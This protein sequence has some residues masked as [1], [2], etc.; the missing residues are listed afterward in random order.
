[1]NGVETPVPDR[2][3]KVR[4]ATEARAALSAGVIST[5]EI[6][7]RFPKA[8]RRRASITAFACFAIFYCGFALYVR[9]VLPGWVFAPAGFFLFIRYFDASHEDIHCRDRD[10]RIWNV[11]RLVSFVLGPLHLCYT[12]LARNHR[13]HHAHEGKEG[14]PDRWMME[15]GWTAAAL[16]SLTQP[17]QALVRHIKANGIDRR[18]ALDLGLH[19]SIWIG[20]AYVCT[21]PQFLLYNAL[22]RFGNGASWFV[23]THVLH[24]KVLYRGFAPVRP[25]AWLRAAWILLIGRNNL[26]AITYHFL[27]HAYGF[28]PARRLPD[29]SAL[30]M[31]RTIHRVA[32]P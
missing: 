31:R 17:E 28:V 26:N 3:P 19:L 8:G 9:G 30:I 20:L 10:E 21:L 12:H 5:G 7:A 18:L 23:F 24:R 29:A 11:L 27:H 6:A 2:F 16:H 13:L 32:V 14:D 15:A 25:P 1:M 4:G 22:V